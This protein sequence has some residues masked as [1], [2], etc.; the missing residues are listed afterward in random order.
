MA[1]SGGLKFVTIGLAAFSVV[2]L[3]SL[4]YSEQAAGSANAADPASQNESTLAEIVVT[5]QK[6]EQRLSDVGLTIAAFSGDELERQGITDVAQLVKIVP[7]LSYFTTTTSTPVLSLRGVGFN[8]SSLAAYP[9]IS[10][11]V[12]EVPLPFPVMAS[13]A[14]LDVARVE[15]LKG[16]QGTLFGD[17]STAGAINYIA[18]EPTKS[19]AAG[20][21]VTYARFN[22]SELNAFVSGPVSDTLGARFSVDTTHGDDWQKSYTRPS[23]T[24]GEVNKTAARL[25]LNWQPIDQLKIR[26]NL[27]GWVDT[28]QPP[29]AQ[30][31]A[32][33]PAT[34]AAAFPALLNY[35][36]LPS[37]NS[38][39]ADWSPDWGI[40]AHNDFWQAALRGDYDLGGSTLTS[41]TSYS[42][43]ARDERGDL[44]GMSL[45]STNYSQNGGIHSFFQELRLANSGAGP[46]R[47]VGG[48]NVQNDSVLDNNGFDFADATGG[49]AFGFGTANFFAD[50][51]MKNYAGFGNLE[52]DLTSKLVLKGGARYTQAD[53]SVSTCSYDAGD[54]AAAGV[55]T[56]IEHLFNPAA[57]AI[58]PGQ[59]FTL[60]P[61]TFTAGLYNAKL[62]QNNVSWRTGIDFKATP[63]ALFYLDVAKG[64]KAG[65][66]PAVQASFQTQFAPVIQESLLDYEAGMK[67]QAL[68]HRL[69][70]ESALFYYD[71]RNKQ[72]RGKLIDPVFGP[73]EALQNIPRSSVRGAEIALSAVPV[74]GLTIGLSGT[75]LEAK[76]DEFTGVNGSGAYADYAGAPM[77]YTPK[78]Q[79]AA[80]AEYQFPVS[81]TVA[82]FVGA[83]LIHHSSTYAAIGTEEIAGTGFDRDLSIEEFTTLDLRAGILSTDERWRVTLWGRN[84]TNKYY[85]TNVD[86]ISDVITRYPAMPATFGITLS[87]RTK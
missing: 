5:A 65:S 61:N 43:Y 20:G 6:R 17:N 63:D 36:L 77:P 69:S 30:L 42:T 59:C 72:L 83:N 86:R 48:M 45:A 35:P 78:V 52:Y 28:S 38:R 12:D 62:D 4:A 66:F 57:P 26:L 25:L 21:D 76:I 68:D 56:Y 31:V 50:Q 82:G 27:N 60:N 14:A 1:A 44:D 79:V 51:K 39:L 16:P 24:L 73:L 85:W 64:Y 70:L 67:L 81:G 29:A 46:L 19:F 84:V 54:G 34:P 10:V 47:W 74:P 13:Q 55:F 87:L 40:E 75:W 9:T 2:G 8:E 22:T 58:L 18:A 37:N 33:T 53:R 3:S 23:D 41:I 49:R 80:N 7:G 32:I 15:V 11:Y 71:Y